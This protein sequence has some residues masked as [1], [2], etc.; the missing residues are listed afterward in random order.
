MSSPVITI[1][2]AVFN[3]EQTIEATLKSVADQSYPN[4]EYI[5]V[6]GKSNDR[7]MEIV[8]SYDEFVDKV[9][10][11]KDSGIYDAFN[12]GV[13][14]SSGDYIYFLNADDTLYDNNTIENIASILNDHDSVSVLYGNIIRNDPMMKIQQIYGRAFAERDFVLGYMPP[15]QGMFVSRKLFFKYGLFDLE[16]KCSSDFDFVAKLFVHESNNILYV[17]RVIAVFQI[18]GLSTQYKTRIIALKE[19]EQLIHKHFNETVDLTS[20]EIKNNALY[21]HWL[22]SI[23]N[24][25]KGITAILRERNIKKIAIFGTMNTAHYLLKDAMMEEIEV[26]TFIDNNKHMLDKN[27]GGIRI[28]PSD[29]LESNA[30]SIDAIIVSLESNNDRYVIDELKSKYG[31]QLQIISW[32]QLV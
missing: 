5:V 12:K 19:N 8:K 1:I 13:K 11:E 26:K 30:G 18:G 25:G 4:I 29:W 15:H 21:R 27:I 23:L 6:D 17:D 10:S 31:K 32:K 7:T 28:V 14:A 20:T 24:G 22:E 3:G 2:T 16:Y 9:I